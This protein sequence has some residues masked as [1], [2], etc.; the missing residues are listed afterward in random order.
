MSHPQRSSTVYAEVLND[1]LCLYNREGRTVH[2]LN[3]SLARVWQMC[4]GHTSPADMADRLRADLAL[5]LD[6][7]QASSAGAAGR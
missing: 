2:A 6:A 3:P 5:E 7:H 4:D 1:E